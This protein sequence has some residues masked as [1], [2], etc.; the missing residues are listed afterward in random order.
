MVL[1][2]STCWKSVMPSSMNVFPDSYWED[3]WGMQVADE[4]ILGGNEGIEEKEKY[5]SW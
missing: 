5:H 2:A 3:F 1:K 4:C